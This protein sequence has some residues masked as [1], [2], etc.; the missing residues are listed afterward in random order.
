MANMSYC[1]FENTFR[2]MQDCFEHMDD[3]DLSES[4]DKYRN[5][6]IELAQQVASYYEDEDDNEWGAKE[7][8]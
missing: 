4:E 7:A 3:G 1:R 8:S 6:L 5:R 2:D